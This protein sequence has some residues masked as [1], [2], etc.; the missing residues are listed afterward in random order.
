MVT[1]VTTVVRRWHV[2]GPVLCLPHPSWFLQRL[3]AAVCEHRWDTRSLSS[4]L[5]PSMPA[6]V[7]LP[8][9]AWTPEL[10]RVS[11]VT[12]TKIVSLHLHFKLICVKMGGI[13]EASFFRISQKSLWKFWTGKG[14]HY[15]RNRSQSPLSL[16][17]A[18]PFLLLH[19]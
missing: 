7:C 13:V 15:P 1:M 19:W 14:C 2:A 9:Y 4:D 11:T 17:S 10:W 12:P 3:E 6:L 18:S 5:R 8:W 16:L